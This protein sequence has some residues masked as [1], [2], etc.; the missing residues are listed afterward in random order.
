MRWFAAGVLLATACVAHPAA[1]ELTYLAEVRPWRVFH[2]SEPDGSS[3]CGI[4]QFNNGL[5][6]LIKLNNERE[7][8][9]HLSKDS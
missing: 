3:L 9:I 2:A 7:A 8:F 4:S 1:A 5:G 6:F